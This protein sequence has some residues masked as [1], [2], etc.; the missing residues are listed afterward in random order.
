MGVFIALSER[1]YPPKMGENSNLSIL[2]LDRL[3]D[4]VKLPPSIGISMNFTTTSNMNAQ[5]EATNSDMN[6]Q[7]E[8]TKG[9][10]F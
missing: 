9:K 2:D 4:I 1:Y 3:L 5:N 8:A 7:N 10:K 6:A